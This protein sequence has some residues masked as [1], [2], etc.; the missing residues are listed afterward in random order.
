VID[1]GLGD[2]KSD[3]ILKAV[4]S[5]VLGYYVPVAGWVYTAVST[6]ENLK[7]AKKGAQAGINHNQATIARIKIEKLKLAQQNKL[8]ADLAALNAQTDEADAAGGEWRNYLPWIIGL[9]IAGAGVLYLTRRNDSPR[10]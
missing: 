9:A 4:A 2:A 6:S 8:V 7:T 1:S 10:K 5:T 3:A